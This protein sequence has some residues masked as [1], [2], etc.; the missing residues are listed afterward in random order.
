MGM[1]NHTDIS[2][3]PEEVIAH[4]QAQLA[5]LERDNKALLEENDRL[6]ADR[7]ELKNQIHGLVVNEVECARKHL[8][9]SFEEKLTQQTNK[10]KEQ[11]EQE[12]SELKCQ[13]TKELSDLCAKYE[14]LI[15][16][17]LLA[18]Q[19]YYGCKSEKVIPGQLSLFNDV[20]FASDISGTEPLLDEVIEKK[21]RRRGG[22]RKIDFSKLEQ[23]VI[24]H[25]LPQEEQVC[26]VCGDK[27]E[28]FN[29]EVSYTL[30]LVPAHLIAEKHERVVY[31]CKACCEDN[32]A[33]SDTPS[34]IK[35]ADMPK[36][37]IKGSLASASLISY[38]LHAKYTNALPL[39]RL[40]QD[41]KCLGVNISRQNMA[42]WTI[43]VYEKWLTLLH[44]RMKEK[45]LEKDIIHADETGIQ[46]LKEPDRTPKQ[47]SYMWLFAASG[48]ECPLYIYEYHPTRARSVPQNFLAGWSGTLMTDGYK[49]Y[50]DLGPTITNTA[51]L[52]H[53]RRKFA[54][55]VKTAGGDSLAQAAG[56]IALAARQKIDEMFSVDSRFYELTYVERK[57]KRDTYL[58]PLMKSFLRWA[59]EQKFKVL[60]KSA[61]DEALDYAITYWPF[62]LNILKDGR[63]ELSNN[64]AE[65]A[66][67]P[68]VI[69]RK[70][71]L[72]SDTPHGAHASA[73]IY[74]IVVT[75][76]ANGIKPRDY[77]EWVLT[78]M[79]NANNASDPQFLDGLI[80]GIGTLPPELY[81]DP[82]A[83]EK[84]KML[85]DDPIIDID[86][87]LFGELEPKETL[88]DTHK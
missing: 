67:K 12:K 48:C 73:A 56:S 78:V 68:F 40:E 71:F 22:K 44:A 55:I 34:V 31:R 74:S 58:A 62:V 88:V 17:Y 42:N 81:M 35:R 30:R 39:Y 3:N 54:E 7:L 43:S 14:R 28:E 83:A 37:P 84:A 45:L 51:C 47:K 36:S 6:I 41:F 50:F 11:F 72:F 77:L 52:V 86:P 18:N 5:I 24:R 10:L 38:I 2:C 87:V 79:P 16:K 49:P 63:L 66:I 15:E 60:P 27:L 75:A 13:H 57:E 61:L 21:P 59:K 53:I 46:V 85:A 9:A 82:Q 64:L 32:A 19:R 69:G 25:E 1:K 70:N 23:V 33:G 20:E 65:R 29:V 80:P 76:K 26:E 8:Q 4:L